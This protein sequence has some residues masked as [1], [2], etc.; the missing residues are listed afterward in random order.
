MS[1]YP[2]RLLAR[3]LTL[4]CALGLLAA[5][6][7]LFVPRRTDHPPERIAAHADVVI[8]PTAIPA[9]LITTTTTSTVPVEPPTTEAPPATQSARPAVAP[10]SSVEQAIAAHFGD[11]YDQ[12]V[13]VA[14]CE[15]SLNP[16]A[17]SPDGRNFGLFQIN[18]VHRDDFE[19]FTGR[20]WDDAI[21]DPDANAA[22]ARKLYDG[23]GGWRRDWACAWAAG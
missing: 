11:V 2:H 4:A 20:T 23:H 16:N 18:V 7:V 22:Y 6:T 8:N 3:A 13:A 15:S 19:Q 5:I 1:R 14:D 21:F 10:A 12:A 17:M 9:G